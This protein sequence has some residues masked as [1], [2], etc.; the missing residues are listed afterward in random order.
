MK[1]VVKDL[2]MLGVSA[3]IVLLFVGGILSTV[4]PGSA[5]DLLPYRVSASV[6]LLGI[7]G[8][9]CTMIV[10]GLR[11]EGVDRT[12]RLLILILGLVMLVIYTAG[13]SFLEWNVPSYMTGNQT[14]AYESRPTALGIPGFETGVALGALVLVF[15]ALAFR[16]RRG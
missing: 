7:G 9:I 16:R 10:A 5:T 6:K 13:S 11:L 8:L 3:G 1:Y 15:A 14:V 4:F 2:V 12:L